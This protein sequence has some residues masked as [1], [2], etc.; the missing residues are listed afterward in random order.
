MT[1]TLG[2][3][4]A[5]FVK[6]TQFKHHCQVDSLTLWSFQLSLQSCVLAVKSMWNAMLQ[7]KWLQSQQYDE[8]FFKCSNQQRMISLSTS[9][10]HSPADNW[11]NTRLKQRSSDS[12]TIGNVDLIMDLMLY[13]TADLAHFPW[14][15]QTVQHHL[16]IE[17]SL[18]SCRRPV[19]KNILYFLFGWA[20]SCLQVLLARGSLRLANQG[21]CRV[22]S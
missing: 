9:L 18:S 3:S 21:A 1:G 5:T 7:M 4:A 11:F 19:P 15:P 2:R 12:S 8:I 14:E 17:H 6:L 10:F 13:R 16:R 22:L 20:L